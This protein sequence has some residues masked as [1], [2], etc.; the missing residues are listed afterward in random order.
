[1][2][3]SRGRIEKQYISSI[4]FLDQ[5]EILPD[6]LDVTM[7]EKSF[8]DVMELL[9][10]MERTKTITYHNFVNEELYGQLTTASAGT[11]NS[12]GSGQGDV[13]VTLTTGNGTSPVRVGDL[14][15][16]ASGHA[17][18]VYERTAGSSGDQIKIKAVDPKITST[19]LGVANGQKI[20][21]FSFAAGEGSKGPDA[22]RWSLTK[23]FNQVQI[24]KGKSTVTDIES[25]N[26]VEVRIKGKHYYMYKNQVDAFN[27]FKGDISFAMIMG[28][29][30]DTNFSSATP[31]L[32]DAEGNPVQTTRG[33]DEYIKTYGINKPGATVDLALYA[34]LAKDLR[35]RRAP[36]Q[37][38]AFMGIEQE[39]VHDDLFRVLPS[40]GGF[41]DKA[42]IVIQGQEVDLSLDRFKVYSYEYIKVNLPILD[43][44]QVTYFTGSAGFEKNAYLIPTDQVKTQDNGMVDR[45]RCRYMQS[46]D[47]DFR[48]KE[49]LTGALAP[50]PTD[51]RS[52]LNIDYE[53]IMGLEMLGVEHCVRLTLP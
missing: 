10:R 33:V 21:T 20:A 17:A 2:P 13:T 26:M 18:Y 25:A 14:V 46:P 30:S 37:Y 41:S 42:R 34:A 31:S 24:F 27:R 52:V 45:L 5:R 40:S 39:I 7:E 15:M 44:N 3:I 29:M 32:V 35:K 49:T 47:W 36:R 38:F 48:Y 28:Q 6:I 8:V 19:Q 53:A 1:M 43:H 9:Q 22:L 4:D 11:D 23:Y 51:D 12:G 50:T 16:L